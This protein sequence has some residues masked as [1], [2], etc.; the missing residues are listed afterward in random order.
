SC[1][2]SL[3]SWLLLSLL[4]VLPVSATILIFFHNIYKDNQTGCKCEDGWEKHK[5]KCY[6]FS[7][8]SSWN[9]SRTECIT[10]GGDLV[11]IDSSEE[12]ILLQ[13]KNGKFWIGL[14]DSAVEGRWLWVDGSPLNESGPSEPQAPGPDKRPPRSEPVCT[15]TPIW[16][17]QICECRHPLLC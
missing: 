14:T 6:Y 1:W 11:K 13:K 8:S 5:G 9:K 4:C 15:W 17:F 3:L 12:Q 7:I 16:K 10:K 2:L